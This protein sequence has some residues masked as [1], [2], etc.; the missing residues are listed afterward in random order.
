MVIQLLAQFSPIR[1]YATI[2]RTSAFE[3]QIPKENSGVT[4][5]WP[6]ETGA[7]N[8]GLGATPFAQAPLKQYPNTALIKVSRQILNST[9]IVNLET[10]IAGLVA[11]YIAQ[12]EGTKFVSG[13]GS[14]CPTG[15]LN[16]SLLTRVNTE[17]VK[18]ITADDFINLFFAVP[19][20]YRS[21][22]VWLMN[23][24]I[25]TA[26]SKMKAATTGEYLLGTLAGRPG[27]QLLGR[28]ILS[29]PDLAATYTAGNEEIAIFGDLAGYYISENPNTTM[30]RLDELYAAT[31]E[32]GFLFEFLK[33]GYPADG[34]GLRVLKVKA[35]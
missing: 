22:G 24:A 18:V 26:I 33:G 17:G 5:G 10:F 35:A 13:D 30:L 28:P 27:M 8:D 7:R 9:T 34:Q 4:C 15:L 31:G 19:E 20:P 2:L 3:V 25:L 12:S 32:V 16:G 29:A 11:R 23:D 21:R 1:Q 14:S 6:G